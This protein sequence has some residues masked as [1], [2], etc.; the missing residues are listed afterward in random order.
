MGRAL[1]AN[2]A[3]LGRRRGTFENMDEYRKNLESVIQGREVREAL[4]VA[5][6][7]TNPVATASTECA[8]NR[9]AL[10]VVG[11]RRS[12]RGAPASNAVAAAERKLAA[13]DFKTFAYG[14][15][16]FATN[17]PVI[18]G[19]L[20]EWA[21]VKPFALRG[22]LKKTHW[23]KEVPAQWED[24]QY[25]M[26]QWDY[27]GF[28]FA[29]RMV[30]DEDSISRGAKSFWENDCLEL[31]FDFSNRRTD[32]RSEDQ[33]QVWF[34]PLGSAEGPGVIGGEI[35]MP[36][37]KHVLIRDQP[38]AH[39]APKMAVRRTA[40]PRG[41][42]VEIYMPLACFRH[43]DFTPGRII[44]FDFSTNN[45]LE[46]YFR[47][48]CLLGKEESMTPS[49]WGDLVLLGSD[50]TIAAIKPRTAQPLAAIIPGEPLGVRLTD[51]DMNTDPRSRNQI[52]VRFETEHGQSLAGWLQETDVNTGVFEGSVDTI[53]TVPD[54]IAGIA[55]NALPVVS[56]EYVE[57]CYY[58]QA[59]RY[60]ERNYEARQRVPVGVPVMRMA[61]RR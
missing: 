14:G 7:L 18:D 22:T 16:P 46:C 48:T 47:W 38:Q 9:P 51:P 55:S 29:Y 34:W 54:E 40:N 11:T 25:L 52:K 21:G 20:S 15:A 28:Y 49:I 58:D 45:G 12:L 3:S 37:Y 1:K 26:V 6:S 8:S 33:Q 56:G 10:I 17:P 57:I 61:G 35:V 31:W 39:D 60:G 41:Y 32:N 23:K 30:D 59:R 4:L 19:D 36:G 43:P 2:G 27:T 13:A 44:A 53:E 24:N 42:T 50:A 5:P